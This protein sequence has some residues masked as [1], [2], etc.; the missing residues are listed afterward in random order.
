[1]IPRVEEIIFT[2]LINSIADRCLNRTNYSPAVT[3]LALALEIVTVEVD[4][5]T[6]CVE[7]TPNIEYLEAPA[8]AASGNSMCMRYDLGLSDTQW[9]ITG[10]ANKSGYRLATNSGSIVWPIRARKNGH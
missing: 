10:C 9:G 7:L 1:M 4:V 5:M 8:S 2:K 6:T 3:T